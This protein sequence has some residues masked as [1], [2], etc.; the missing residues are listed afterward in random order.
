MGG[1][2]Y[3]YCIA[4]EG[5]FMSSFLFS[6][7]QVNQLFIFSELINGFRINLTEIFNIFTLVFTI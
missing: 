3:L 4:S 6:D 5:T 7:V 2:V 1:G